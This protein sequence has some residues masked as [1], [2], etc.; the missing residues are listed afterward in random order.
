MLFSVRIFSLFYLH[1]NLNEETRQNATFSAFCDKTGGNG[2]L[3]VVLY[4]SST[5]AKKICEITMGQL[6]L[7]STNID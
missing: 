4:Y 7:S 3:T 2:S 6:R 5:N 1:R